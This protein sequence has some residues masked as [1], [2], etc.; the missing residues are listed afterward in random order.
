MDGQLPEEATGS[1][2]GLSY[3]KHVDKPGLLLPKARNLTYQKH[4]EN[5]GQL[6][7]RWA[8]KTRTLPAAQTENAPDRRRTVMQD[9]TP[10]IEIKICLPILSMHLV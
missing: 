2:I 3:Q 6:G 5:V 10:V 4:V 8:D 7:T 9:H 1:N